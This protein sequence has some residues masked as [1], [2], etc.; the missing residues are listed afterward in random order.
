[1]KSRVF[2]RTGR[3]R[4]E[5]ADWPMT[6]D[7][8]GMTLFLEEPPAGAPWT[9]SMQEVSPT[10]AVHVD[11]LATMLQSRE[12]IGTVQDVLDSETPWSVRL[13]ASL[14]PGKAF[15]VE[16]VIADEDVGGRILAR[17]EPRRFT[18][19]MSGSGHSSSEILVVTGDIGDKSDM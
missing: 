16:I 2:N 7:E 8:G 3:I 12:T 13:P 19:G 17:S 4:I 10:A 15:R 9:D 18:S 5:H 6:M 11:I 14:P 1:M